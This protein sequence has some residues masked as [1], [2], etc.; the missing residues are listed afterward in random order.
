MNIGVRYK[1]I[2]ELPD[3]FGN[4]NYHLN[5]DLIFPSTNSEGISIVKN[6]GKINFFV[7]ANN[8]GKSRFVRGLFKL[9]K[10]NIEFLKGENS[11]Q[12]IYGIIINKLVNFPNT[13]PGYRSKKLSSKFIK[14]LQESLIDQKLNFLTYISKKPDY[15]KLITLITDFNDEFSKLNK[16]YSTL[17]IEDRDYLNFIKPLLDEIHSLIIEIDFHHREKI[18]NKIYLPILRY[19]NVNQ[20]LTKE[21]YSKTIEENYGIKEFT[22]TGLD[23]FDEIFKLQGQTSENRKKKEKFEEYLS[24]TFFDNKKVIITAST[25][26]NHKIYF[27][28]D[29]DE[30]F[31]Y[32]LGDGLQALII[33]MFPLFN[34][35]KNDWIFIDEPET[36]LHPGLQKLFLNTIINDEFLK[37]KNLRYFITTHSNHFLD[38]SIIDKDVSIFQFEKIN[39]ESISFQH[40]QKPSQETLN[41]LGVSN[42]S[43]LLA[44]TSVWIEGP[45]DRR[46]LSYFLH[47]YAIKLNISPLIEDIDFAFFE[48]GGSLI[49][50]Y[51]FDKDYEDSEELVRKKIN[52]FA[53]SN[54]IYLLADNDNVKGNTQKGKRRIKLKSLSEK[55]QN[56]K[57]QNTE[58]TEIENLLPPT[59]ISEFAK[60]LLKDKS[61]LEKLKDCKISKKEYVK[62]RIGAFY[63]DLF[64]TLKIPKSNHKAFKAESGTLSTDYKFKL[65]E[66][67]ITSKYNY[68]D[69]IEENIILDKIVKDLYNFIKS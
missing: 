56:F 48:Y 42:S 46:Y 7:G 40:L 5:G 19:A 26:E 62:K 67:L 64:I 45:T 65:C 23:L 9:E 6:F 18:N 39:K 53:L 55:N 35:S 38:M 41:I 12:N 22:F 60:T 3:E 33:L 21:I 15:E 51:L 52:S 43:V 20:Y 4:L 69:L 66:F 57:Y 25:V 28:I 68:E 32:N 61:D 1:K 17:N 63:E 34:A 13:R 30:K 54:H 2:T 44:N 24:K 10:V 8:S 49:S 58:A 11:A 31:L 36:H 50:H 14:I 29:G 16:E 27:E 37:R 47:Q 59:I